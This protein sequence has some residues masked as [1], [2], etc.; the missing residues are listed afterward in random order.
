MTYNA[1]QYDWPGTLKANADTFLTPQA[2]LPTKL[3]KMVEDYQAQAK[4]AAKRGA[5]EE[6]AGN[7]KGSKKANTKKEKKE[8]DTEK[9]GKG[10]D[11]KPKESKKRKKKD[12]KEDE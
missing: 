5:D 6:D 1:R 7:A 8:K 10:K 2:E 12:D 11:T 4:K 3:R 9:E